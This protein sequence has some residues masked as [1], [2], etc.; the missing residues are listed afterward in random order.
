L[1]DADGACADA[2]EM[3]AATSNK[4]A[5]T[6]CISQAPNKRRQRRPLIIRGT[7][8]ARKAGWL[9]PAQQDAF[10][11]NEMRARFRRPLDCGRRVRRL[12]P[13]PARPAPAACRNWR[14]S[15]GP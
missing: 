1:A 14:P 2:V 7:L 6:I 11:S 13:C 5:G 4:T 10:N 12:T 15:E 3:P 8:R 9:P